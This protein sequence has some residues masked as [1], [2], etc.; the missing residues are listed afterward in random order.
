MQK[1]LNADVVRFKKCLESETVDNIIRAANK[2]S[3]RQQMFEAYEKISEASYEILGRW[4]DF[5]SSDHSYF[6]EDALQ[7]IHSYRALIE[8]NEMYEWIK[9]AP[10]PQQ[11]FET[12]EFQNIT[13]DNVID[14]IR[15]YITF[16]HFEKENSLSRLNSMF[17]AHPS[18]IKLY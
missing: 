10:L 18:L 13:Q 1:S 2:F 11:K 16:H 9:T 6:V 14:F 12:K 17:N 7:T 8:H 15:G 4:N 5:E 3:I